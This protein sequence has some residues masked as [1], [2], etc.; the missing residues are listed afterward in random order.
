[1]FKYSIDIII[2]LFTVK[3]VPSYMPTQLS[4]NCSSSVDRAVYEDLYHE[5][6]LSSEN[7]VIAERSCR[8]KTAL[9]FGANGEL[10]SSC[11]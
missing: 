8:G 9:G 11:G 6:I 7:T 3:K 10:D 4:K 5:R 1:L 2:H